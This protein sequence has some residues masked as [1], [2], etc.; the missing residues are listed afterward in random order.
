MKINKLTFLFCMVSLYTA[1]GCW[2]SDDSY[3]D[4][5]FLE[6]PD[7]IEVEG[8]ETNF[9][10]GE[11]LW[12]LGSVSRYLPTEESPALLDVFKTTRSETFR[13]RI[14]LRRQ[15]DSGNYEYINLTEE[16]FVIDTGDIDSFYSPFVL[17]VLNETEDTYESRIGIV[18]QDPGVYELDINFLEASNPERSEFRV[19]VATNIANANEYWYEFTVAE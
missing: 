9:T 14:E 4:N 12:V 7:L 17:A 6:V 10:A 13:Y 11:T 16:D 18:L 15:T 3:Q 5:I 2:Y 1:T 8:N 19:S